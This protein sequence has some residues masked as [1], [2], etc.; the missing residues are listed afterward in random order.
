MQQD[1]PYKIWCS[2]RPSTSSVFQSLRVWIRHLACRTPPL[3]GWIY[4][5]DIWHPLLMD[6]SRLRFAFALPWQY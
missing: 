1:C 3:R 4:A 5:G 2:V 6:L